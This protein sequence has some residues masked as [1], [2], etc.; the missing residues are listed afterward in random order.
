MLHSL[1][2][3]RGTKRLISVLSPQEAVQQSQ[4][5]ATTTTQTELV[6]ASLAKTNY[7]GSAPI[8][9][10]CVSRQCFLLDQPAPVSSPIVVPRAGDSIQE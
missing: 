4:T 5:R 3:I 8:S 10:Y 6:Q 1:Q 7:D 9:V 2:V